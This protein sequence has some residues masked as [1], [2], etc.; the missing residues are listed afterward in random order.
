MSS[1][2]RQRG[3]TYLLVL[4]FIATVAAGLAAVGELWSTSRQQERE[5]ELLFAGN[6]IRQAIGAYYLGTEGPVKRYPASLEDLLKDPRY[7][8]TQRYLR[9]LYPDP[10][11][12]STEWAL[13]KAPQGGIMG[14]ASSSERA[15]LKRAGFLDPNRAFEEQA[16]RLK[17]KLRYRDWEF[18]YEPLLR[19]TSDQGAGI[20]A[21]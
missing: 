8:Y 9:R 17:D 16:V 5:R 6:A 20:N 12:G 21:P 7:I 10:M 1:A 3:F 19:R 15:P 18:I 14:I 11:T 13:I 2:Y 4:F